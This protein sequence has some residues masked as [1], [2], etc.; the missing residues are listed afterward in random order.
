M[1]DDTDDDEAGGLIAQR[2]LLEETQAKERDATADSHQRDIEAAGKR[3]DET[4]AAMVRQ[5][6]IDVANWLKSQGPAASRPGGGI[7]VPGEGVSG[8]GGADGG[9]GASTGGNAAASSTG[10]EG[11]SSDGT[12]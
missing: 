7:T 6:Q 8:G 1:A 12:V 10:A 2:R 11:S 9:T 3:Q 4:Y 5:Q